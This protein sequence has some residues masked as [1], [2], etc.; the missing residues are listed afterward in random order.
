MLLPVYS[1]QIGD[2]IF[3]TGRKIRLFGISNEGSISPE[4]FLI[5]E[6]IEGGKGSNSVI[7]FLDKFLQRSGDTLFQ[8]SS[9]CDNCTG[10]NKTIC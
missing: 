10:Q 7:S 9:H 3:K 8:I 4:S 1:D 2:L 6:A 5:D